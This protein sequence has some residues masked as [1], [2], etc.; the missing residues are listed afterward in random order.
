MSKRNS[1]GI[2]RN[3]NKSAKMSIAILLASFHEAEVMR[4]KLMGGYTFAAIA[5]RVTSI[6]RGEER[7]HT[8]IPSELVFPKDYHVTPQ[9][10]H[11]AYL[12]ALHRESRTNAQTFRELNIQRCENM[13]LALQPAVQAGDR[14]AI[15]AELRAIE[16]EAGLQNT[17]TTIYSDS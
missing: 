10:C 12:R 5:T 8:P 4:M 2:F 6:G 14:E 13:I 1:D 17:A 16:V 11:K 7:S 3:N 9:G 15:K